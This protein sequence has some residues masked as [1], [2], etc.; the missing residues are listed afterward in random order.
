MQTGQ[1]VLQ[2]LRPYTPELTSWFSHFGQIAANYDAN[3]HY[4][5]VA[6]QTGNFKLNGSNQLTPSNDQSLAQYP[7]TGTARCPGSAA[8]PA[9]DGSNPFT[10]GGATDCDPTIQTP[11]P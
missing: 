10:D 11:G 3:G 9:G 7:K 2:F 4:V 1:I 5:R 6:T 8:Q